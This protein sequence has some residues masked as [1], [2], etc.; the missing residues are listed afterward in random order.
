MEL[1][2]SELK[3]KEGQF[4]SIDERTS[5]DTISFHN[6]ELEVVDDLVV[7]GGATFT[8]EE[9]VINVS[10]DFSTNV[11]EHCRRCLEPIETK[12]DRHEEIEFRPNMESEVTSE[13]DL[14]IYRYESGSG[15]IDLLPYIIR[16]LKLDLD[17]Y[18]LCKEDC[19]GLCPKCGAN[20]NK[21]EDHSCETEEEGEAKDPRMEKLAELL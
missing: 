7:T 16:F 3:S 13:G 4:V 14:S 17:P 21:E 19:K 10:I 2:L 8:S 9:E 15:T 20:L 1:K 18:P 6:D 11:I 12:I 5:L